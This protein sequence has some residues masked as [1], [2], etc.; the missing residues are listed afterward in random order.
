[1]QRKTEWKAFIAAKISE[2][3]AKGWLDVVDGEEFKLKTADKE[4]LKKVG[5]VGSD[6]EASLE[7]PNSEDGKDVDF[8]AFSS[9]EEE[10][11]SDKFKGQALNA[12]GR[13]DPNKQTSGPKGRIN[14]TVD[15]SKY[16]ANVTKHRPDEERQERVV[17]QQKELY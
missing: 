3:K 8:L 6:G 11:A 9:D 17:K 16:Y 1:M 10:K 14:P 15:Q 2:A 5:L 4:T 13:T 7:D 12:T